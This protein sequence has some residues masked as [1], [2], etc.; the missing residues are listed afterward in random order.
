MI[1]ISDLRNHDCIFCGKSL[2]P[3]GKLVLTEETTMMCGT[4][5]E[6]HTQMT[7]SNGFALRTKNYVF[8]VNGSKINFSCLK[9]QQ[10]LDYE[11]KTI[12]DV[13][14]FLRNDYLLQQ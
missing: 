2:N 12:Q 6:S 4:S 13:I 1:S 10:M 5:D 11:N 7:H 14:E 9:T 8:S 3:G